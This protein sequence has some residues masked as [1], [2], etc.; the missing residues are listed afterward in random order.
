[1]AKLPEILK[2]RLDR[3]RP[4]EAPGGPLNAQSRLG[5]GRC[6]KV[7]ISSMFVDFVCEM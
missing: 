7:L 3:P 6:W 2:F 4:F 1:M 5:V